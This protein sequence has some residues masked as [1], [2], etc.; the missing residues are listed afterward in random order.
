MSWKKVELNE[1]CYISSGGTPDRSNLS[2]FKG[3]IPWSK[4]S[5]IEGADGG[6]I[7]TTEEHISEEGLAAINNRIFPKGTLL[8]AIYGSVGKVAFAG[9]EMSSNQAILGIRIKDEN[10][11]IY[12]Y[13]KYWF[14]TIKQQ[15][16]ER[17]VGGTLQN[18]SLGI[19]KQL[20]I[21]LPPL[22]IQQRIA[23]ILDAADALKR[24]DQELLKK[25]DELAQAIFIDMFADPVKNEKGWEKM[26]LGDI[27]DVGSSVRVFVDELVDHGIPFFRGTEIGNLSVGKKIAP[28]LFITKE[29][30]NKLKN[31]GGVPEIGDLLMP[32][33]CPDGRIFEVIEDNPFYFK[34][35]RVL[36]IK[37]NKAK[38]NSTYLKIALKGIFNKNYINIA[39]GST[40]AELKIF[41]LKKIELPVPPISIQTQFSEIYQVV[42]SQMSNSNSV[43]EKS[44]LLFDSLIKKTFTGEL[45]Y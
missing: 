44:T 16:L 32:S 42:M 43:I 21:P 22:P 20:Q 10:L 35:G 37:V 5:D 34:D 12:P 30:Y 45:V 4:I 24:K 14:Q 15:L 41:A 38:I 28:S 8:L 2:Y 9:T 27:C 29:H 1:L 33:I 19:V 36:W 40:F 7:Y 3:L 18:I 13:L 39:S 17:A 26:V 6:I 25:Y 31:Q 11:L 23:E